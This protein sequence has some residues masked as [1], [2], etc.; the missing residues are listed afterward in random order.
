MRMR[1]GKYQ[2]SSGAPE[3]YGI[4]DR[5]GMMYNLSALKFQHEFRGRSLVNTGIRVCN[6]CHDKPNHQDRTIRLPPDPVAVNHPR[7]IPDYPDPDVQDELD[8]ILN[9][10]DDE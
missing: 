2:V 5:C 10:E 6:R 1:K 8:L 7:P 9:G 4:C 3:P